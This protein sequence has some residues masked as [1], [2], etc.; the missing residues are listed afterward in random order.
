MFN[1]LRL[2]I[3]PSDLAL[4]ALLTLAAAVAIIRWPAAG[5]SLMPYVVLQ[6]VLL[7][8]FSACAATFA[9]RE[10]DRWVVFV[11]PLVTVAIVFLLYAALGKLGVAAMP[12]LADAGLSK[13]DNWLFGFDPSLCIQPFQTP[14][15]VEFFS[16]A[17]AAFIPYIY[18]SM[19]IGCFGRPP[20]ERDQFLTGWVF[21]YVIIY[22]GYLFVPAHGP[23]V[24]QADQYTV[25]LEGGFFYRLVVLGN[26]MTGGLQGVFPSL[27]VGSSV[28]LCLFDLQT[29]RLRGLTYLPIVLLIYVAT[30][31]LRYHY[32][33]D[34][35]AGTIIAVACVRMGRRVFWNWAM[36]RAAA[37]KPALPGG[38]ADD[39][40]GVP[41]AGSAR[42]AVILSAD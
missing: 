26:D 37:G 12:Y 13:V 35:V 21:T 11:R 22:L 41:G 33:I 29:N 7:L 34:L 2:S 1:R 20:V 42:A 25:A 3:H 32:V 30:I 6:G 24:F 38:E 31:F 15:W 40:P 23:V 16:F 28:Y 8:T 17:Y 18:L 10:N 5:D 4:L 27:H 39:L 9:W 14:S 36:D 19:F